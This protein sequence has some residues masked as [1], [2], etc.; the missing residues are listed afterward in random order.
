MCKLLAGDKTLK[1]RVF[2]TLFLIAMSLGYIAALI[3]LY[4]THQLDDLKPGLT[5]DDVIT[6]FH[7]NKNVTRLTFMINNKM[8][9]FL[10]NDDQRIAIQDWVA[11]GATEEGYM[12]TT[13]EIFET[14]C[15]KCHSLFG[16]SSFAPLT[17]YE[18]VKTKTVP[19]EGRSWNFIARLSHQHF[20]GMS[21]IIFCTAM[22]MFTSDRWMKLKV[23]L[24][25][26]GMIG[27]IGDVG[28]WGL[29]KLWGSFAYLIIA[30]N[31]L[32]SASF[33]AMVLL[34]LYELWIYKE[35]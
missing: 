27:I 26:L 15:V 2:Y 20:L 23:F 6:N 25:S 35:R 19:Y 12:E 30:A 28:G 14:R 9:Q 11:A 1:K 10:A 34:C 17:T 18:E 7:G 31:A 32:H 8:K 5:I 33:A 24:A 16:E 21:F 13:R 4:M 22:I 29:T 3:N